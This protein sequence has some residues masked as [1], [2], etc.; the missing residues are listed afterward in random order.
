MDAPTIFY[1]GLVLLV[2]VGAALQMSRSTV[3]VVV[4]AMPGVILLAVAAARLV[5]S[6]TAL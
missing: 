2:L 5:A 6:A 1:L 3:L 4:I